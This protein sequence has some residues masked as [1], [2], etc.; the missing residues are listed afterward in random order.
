MG[1]ER[2]TH[3]AASFQVAGDGTIVYGP[4]KLLPGSKIVDVGAVY[5]IECLRDRYLEF[6]FSSLF[7][8][9]AQLQPVAHRIKL[10]HDGLRDIVAEPWIFCEEMSDVNLLGL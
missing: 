10:S 6:R 5:Q 7:L 9:V 1:W 4:M 2:V 8:L 3:V